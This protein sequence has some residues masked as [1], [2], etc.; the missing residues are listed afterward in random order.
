MC[1]FLFLFAHALK[2]EFFR[3]YTSMFAYN[4][5]SKNYN[6]SSVY[7]NMKENVTYDI[8]K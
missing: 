7:F 1:K 8:N 3:L 4:F 2:C 6:W 5:P